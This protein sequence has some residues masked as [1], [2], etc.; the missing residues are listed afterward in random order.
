MF[1]IYDPNSK[2]K[3]AAE[4][5]GCPFCMSGSGRTGFSA[6]REQLPVFGRGDS[7]LFFEEAAEIHGVVVAHDGGDLVDVVIRGLKEA[8]GVVDAACEDVLHGGH[9]RDLLETAQ[10]PADAHVPGLGEAFDVD[11]LVIVL[12][13]IPSHGVHLLH[14]LAADAGLLLLP[15]A[16]DQ[17]KEL[18]QIH[19]EQLLIARPAALELMD[20]VL[21]E[22]HIGREHACEEYV[23]RQGDVVMAE[24]VLHVA[25]GK[26]HPIDLGLVLAVIHIVLLLSGQV[27]YH[28]PR[29]DLMVL[30]PYEKMG[31]AGGHIEQLKIQLTPGPYGSKPLAGMQVVGTAAGNDQ[32]F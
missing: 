5:S 23:F 13:E 7:L 27:E 30:A 26:M 18:P 25:A 17:E 20:H 4:R 3:G 11:G 12:V 6:A 24:D 9:A 16:L 14:E 1:Q 10:K 31:L 2:T 21:I 22:L 15:G 8:H 19:G 32:R 29:R 28:V